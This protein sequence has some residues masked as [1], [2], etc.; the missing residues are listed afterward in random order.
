MS[1][2][3]VRNGKE[4]DIVLVVGPETQEQGNKLAKVTLKF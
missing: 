2:V 1:L 3:C 4:I